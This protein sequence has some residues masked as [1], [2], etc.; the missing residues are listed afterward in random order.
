[1]RRLLR[2]AR[3]RAV[4][5]LLAGLVAVAPAAA[6]PLPPLGDWPAI[7]AAARG[8][9][10]HWYAWGGETHINDYIAWVGEV[11]S[12][13][14]GINLVQVKVADTAEAVARVL[15]ETVAGKT[16]GG[17]VDL[18]WING[19]NFVAMK[20]NGLL[21]AEPWAEA[22]PNRALVDLSRYGAPI[23]TDFAVPVDGQQSP[24]GRAQ[25]VYL[26]D[27]GKT[28]QP[29][30]SLEELIRFAAAHPGRFTYPQPP[31]FLGTS[32]LKQI[33]LDTVPDPARLQEPAGAD[34]EALV[35]NA[36]LPVL[37]RLHPHLWRSGKAF[38][39]G[40]AELRRLFADGEILLALTFNPS[41]AQTAIRAGTLPPTTR[42]TTFADGSLGNVHFVAIPANAN[43][44]A[45]ALVV[46]NV[47]LSPEAQARKADPA[48][49][50]DPTVLDIDGLPGETRALFAGEAAV[51]APTLSEPH[52]SWTEII[53]TVWAEEYLK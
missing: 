38:P 44:K 53:E 42:V 37:E 22:L 50:G 36:L 29:P 5:A 19:E 14:Y 17:A 23:L 20:D 41:D 28:P 43:A 27:E 26:Y 39:Q 11:V 10:V 6:E 46:A 33:L 35:R 15:A 52:A 18:V 16:D 25:L 32:F 2:T 12:E 45:G 9:A 47:L 51:D 48:I 21:L 40:V 3:R 13:R 1:M 31:N 24:W 7:E 34:A 49:W 8:Q 30:R 4:G